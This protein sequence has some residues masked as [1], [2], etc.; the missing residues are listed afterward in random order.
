VKIGLVV[1]TA[2][3]RGDNQK[4]PYD[5]IRAIARQ[6]DAD[7]FDSIWLADHLFYRNPGWPL[8][9]SVSCPVR[10]S[11]RAVESSRARRHL[12]NSGA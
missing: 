5:S 6:A 9:E 7:G 3:T 12:R 4:R 11:R 1:F 8:G 10:K 2:N